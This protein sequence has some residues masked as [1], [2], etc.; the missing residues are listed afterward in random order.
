MYCS[1]LVKDAD[2]L[3][4]GSEETRKTFQE[5]ERPPDSFH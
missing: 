4:A 5:P 2:L 1:F 3:F